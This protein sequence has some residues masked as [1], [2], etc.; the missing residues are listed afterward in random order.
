[1]EFL[2]LHSFIVTLFTLKP[3]RHGV[4]DAHL[5]E[6]EELAPVTGLAPPT[7]TFGRVASAEKTR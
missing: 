2:E 4:D 3:P 5:R 6:E 7:K 1:M